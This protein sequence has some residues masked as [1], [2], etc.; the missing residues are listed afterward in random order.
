M[1][2]VG[3]LLLLLL[4]G[5]LLGVATITLVWMLDAW[6][7]PAAADRTSFGPPRDPHV[8][9]SLIVPARHEE[10]VLGD[11]LDRLAEHDHP[12]VEVLV[13]VG[14]DD[15]PTTAVARAASRRHP[16]VVRVV[17]DTNWPKN[18]PKALN[19]ALPE[20][21]GD[22]VGVFDA[23]DEVAPGLLRRVDTSFR[24]PEIAVVQGG[25]QLMNFQT[26][27]WA[28][29]NVLEYFF[30]FRSRLHH[31]A[32]AQVIPLGGNTV[33]F[34]REVLLDAG[35]WDDECLAED[36]E[37]GIR[38]SAR[39]A[40]VAVAYD[41]ALVTREETPHRV[42]ALVRQRTRWNQGFLQ[43][44]AK[45]EWKHQP[46]RRQRQLAWFL[47]MTP[48]LQ[49]A[50]GVLIPFSLISTLVLDL[51]VVVALAMFSPIAVIVV[52]V[53]VETAGLLEFGARYGQRVRPRDHVRL[54]LGALPYQWLLAV[55][56]VRAVTRHARQDNSWEKTLHLGAHR[57]PRLAS[58]T[59]EA[60]G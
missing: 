34:R 31:H 14:H 24:S 17:I 42:P 16:D 22:I 56:A 40:R 59:E 35:G 2:A 29:R 15:G 26:S 3:V 39:G 45:A 20:C 55:A 43:V 48:F 13:V 28:L 37:V 23:E 46:T 12:H 32:R 9:F 54:V 6:R 30:W 18:K 1:G 33:F 47:L 8:S 25:V 57:E 19:R 38:L 36:C 10:A 50:A 27:W 58:V 53:A 52:T 51:P 4:T 60:G 49:A 5:A 11:T 44:L 7:T 21:R 41:P